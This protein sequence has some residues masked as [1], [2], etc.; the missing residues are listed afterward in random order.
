[1]RRFL[2]LVVRLIDF[3][4]KVSV[5]L[6]EACLVGLTLLVVAAV[7]FR[8]LL[9]SPFA[10]S[11][12]VGGYLMAGIAFLAFAYTLKVNRHIQVELVIGRLNVKLRKIL[13]IATA[14]I[15]LAWAVPVIIGTWHLW[16][17]NLKSGARASG[18]IETALWIPSSLLILGAILLGLQLLAEIVK[19]SLSLNS[20]EPESPPEGRQGLG[21]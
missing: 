16:E 19:R 11:D 21:E 5:N 1:M 4:S 14:V 7:I 2:R 17:Q 6:S 15:G 20:D 12:E 8:R 13:G 3:L 10:F 18:G 9:N